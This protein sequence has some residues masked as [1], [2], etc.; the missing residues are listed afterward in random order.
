MTNHNRTQRS[1]LPLW[2][3]W[4]LPVLALC[5]L[6][7]LPLSLQAQI[8]RTDEAA[9]K[10][11]EMFID[12]S[13]EKM[14]GNYKEAVSLLKEILKKERDNPVALF[15]LARI[16]EAM[17]EPDKSLKYA[18]EAAEADNSNE[19]ILKFLADL[20]QKK[21]DYEGAAETYERVV[22]L[23]PN[24]EDNY[25]RHAYFLVR[26]EEIKAALKVYD[27]L[28]ER[29][30]ITEEVIRR[31]HALYLGQREDKKAAAELMRLIEAYPQNP[32]YRH[33][34][35]GFYE[36]IGE[37]EKALEVYRQILE[38]DPDNGKAKMALAG[39]S[40]QESDEIRYLAALQAPF[41]DPETPIDVKIQKLRPFL[42]KV[43]ATNDR[44][45]SDAAL[46]LTQTLEMVH[47]ADPKG[48][49]A[50]ADLY[51]HSGRKQ[52][53]LEKYLATLELE[54]SNFMVWE[55]VM[56]L[57]ADRYQFGALRQFT[58]R[59]MD[60]YPNQ[61][62]V[63]YMNALAD[64]HLGETGSALSTLDQ[65]SFMAGGNLRASILVQ[66]LQGL[67][68]NQ[69]GDIGQ[70]DKAFQA[71]LS[72]QSTAPPALA[73]YAYALALRGTELKEAEKMARK[74]NE[75][76]PGQPEY[77]MQLGWVLYQR[78]QHKAAAN[79]LKKAVAASDGQSPT[80]LEYYG[81][82]LYQLGETAEAVSYWKK[83]RAAG[84]RSAD[85]DQKIEEKKLIE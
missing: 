20:Q 31:K 40:G 78:G 15:E 75:L 71:A 10:V 79:W 2:P 4:Q 80:I 60:Y 74:A 13:R 19:W 42:E 44:A 58:E 26:A 38:I 18:Q 21:G 68:Y 85:L 45:L 50:S 73:R 11:E 17:S 1:T 83:A 64:Y 3:A 54:K 56:Q 69:Q 46:K 84:S 36:Q 43:A 55:Q 32:N 12:A 23:Q 25:L 22:E 72:A 9:I 49:A 24:V 70:S 28:E 7:S 53:A 62:I 6:C 41:E 37:E 82:A 30:G 8:G 51:Y 81:D 33:L 5:L 76:L 65:A 57:Y 59:A 66:T 48:F 14:L 77:Q 29:L 61:P 67:I 34:L 39:Q 63:Y 27:D 35:A 47:P 52:Q 16:Y